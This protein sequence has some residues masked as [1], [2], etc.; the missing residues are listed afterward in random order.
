[1]C[2]SN[3]S[4]K[5]P[6]SLAWLPL[7]VSQPSHKPTPPLSLWRTV[8]WHTKCVCGKLYF[9]LYIHTSTVPFFLIMLFSLR[10]PEWFHLF[11]V[12]PLYLL[13][14]PTTVETKPLRREVSRGAQSTPD[15]VWLN[16]L[17]RASMLCFGKTC[18]CGNLRNAL[19][20]GEKTNVR[21]FKRLEIWRSVCGKSLPQLPPFCSRS[22][23]HARIIFAYLWEMSV[24]A[25]K[26]TGSQFCRLWI[27]E[28]YKMWKSKDIFL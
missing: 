25:I 15:F 22:A 16:L 21:V 2:W 14:A 26:L 13:S 11:V 3:T 9:R 1:M 27:M 5:S 12:C 24:T 17:W 20:Y 7:Y 8:V 28:S 19:I 6:P 4:Y 10:L 23:R 18:C